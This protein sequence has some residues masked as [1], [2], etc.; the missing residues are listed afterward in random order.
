M[1]AI[2]V[3]VD[4]WD[5]LAVTLPYNL[6]HYDECMVVTSPADTNTRELCKHYKV[7]CHIT[8]AFYRKGAMFNKWLAL[9]EGLDKFGRDGWI[10][11]IDADI[12]LPRSIDLPPLHIGNIYAPRRRM[13]D[14]P[15]PESMWNTLRLWHVQEFSGFFQLFHG[16]DPVL[17]NPPWHEVDW[18]HAGGAD[19]FF[20]NKWRPTNKI[21]LDF[22]VLH[23]G[24]NGKNWCGR[25]TPLAGQV[26]TEAHIRM[27]KLSEFM[28]RRRVAPKA[29]LTR[30]DHEKLK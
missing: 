14:R 17:P 22:E 21:R 19:T 11:I 16:R 5:Y 2:I 30:Y 28:E 13:G 24:P 27:Q 29:N 3:C 26:P 25:A 10:L 12:M 20:Q 18:T 9:E 6:H 15:L 1:R 23:L 8:D 7:Q 4:Y